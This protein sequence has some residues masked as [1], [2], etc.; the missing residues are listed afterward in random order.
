M[1][2]AKEGGLR[3][4]GEG[5][6]DGGMKIRIWIAIAVAGAWAD[7]A[8]AA[9]GLLLDSYSAVVNGRVITVGEVMD[10]IRPEQ[11]R[12]MRQY[13]GEELQEKM[14]GAFKEGRDRLIA[15]ELILADFKAQGATL[16]ERAIEDHI[17]GIIHDRFGN[18]RT[19]FLQ[20]LA[21]ERTTYEEWRKRMQNQLIIQ[22]MR[23][24]EVTSKILVTPYD[25]QKEY[26]AHREKYAV[27]EKVR[28]KLFVLPEGA[29]V[30][31]GELAERVRNGALSLDDAVEHF[32]MTVQDAGEA[33]ETS[34]LQTALRDALAGAKDGELV[35]PVELDGTEYL[36]QLVERE[37]GR[38]EPLEDVADGIAAELRKR[39]FERLDK[40]WL[41]TLKGKYYVQ[42]FAN[43]LFK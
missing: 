29:K 13:A 22:V 5:L 3:G 40:I 39:E 28:L 4:R 41:N 18:D 19:A 25:I 27:P 36:V 33:L 35:G 14:I 24:R 2:G 10:E 30:R 26:D 15:D 21:E 42:V 32:H 11:A 34:S 37:E 38:V 6:Y 23:Q 8:A 7:C 12:L 43:D 31:L 1:D 9:G 20:A 17:N 16:P